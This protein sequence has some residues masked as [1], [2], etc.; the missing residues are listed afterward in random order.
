VRVVKQITNVSQQLLLVVGN[1]FDCIVCGFRDP[2]CFAIQVYGNA[3]AAIGEK[4]VD[5]VKQQGDMSEE[6]GDVY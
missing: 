6:I 4:G 5:Q 3:V 1:Y 2:R